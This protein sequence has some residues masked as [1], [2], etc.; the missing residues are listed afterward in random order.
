LNTGVMPEKTSGVW[1]LAPQGHW[2]NGIKNLKIF[3][4]PIA[5]T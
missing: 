3:D 4:P 2:Q 1:G 5:F